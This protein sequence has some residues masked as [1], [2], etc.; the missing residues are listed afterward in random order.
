MPRFIRATGRKNN[1]EF[2]EE[3]PHYVSVD[4]LST[5]GTDKGLLTKRCFIALRA[6]LYI[7]PKKGS[8]RRCMNIKGFLYFGYLNV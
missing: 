8:A 3:C 7:F 4:S 5:V 6:T 2:G 1:R